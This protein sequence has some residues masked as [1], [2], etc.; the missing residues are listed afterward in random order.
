[1][2]L[3]GGV[4]KQGNSF[5]GSAFWPPIPFRSCGLVICAVRDRRGRAYG[6]D[7]HSAE[8]S[9]VH[10]TDPAPRGARRARPTRPNTP[11]RRRQIPTHGT[12]PVG[13][14]LRVEQGSDVGGIIGPGLSHHLAF[15]L[16]EVVDLAGVHTIQQQV[17][18]VGARTVGDRPIERC[19][20]AGRVSVRHLRPAFQVGIFARP[21][22]RKHP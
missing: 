2:D 5:R 9:P 18:E 4:R 20:R 19:V 11:R 17:G 16:A 12:D 14:P 3:P 13:S 7:L 15:H 10:G 21:A 22:G 1:M 8:P 6:G